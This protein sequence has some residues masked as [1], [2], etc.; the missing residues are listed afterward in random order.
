MWA[1]IYFAVH[2]NTTLLPKYSRNLLVYRRFIDDIFGIWIPTDSH[3]S[4]WT[5]FQEDTNDFGILKWEFDELSPQVNF[6]DLTISIEDNLI[7][8]KTYQKSMNL[9][10]RSSRWQQR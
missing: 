7:A 3:S 9:Y 6:L 1:T 10:Q 5:A 8:T 4:R 2:E